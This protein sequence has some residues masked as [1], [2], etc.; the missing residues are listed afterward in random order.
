MQI[1]AAK[2]QTAFRFDKNLLASMKMRAKSLGRSLNSYVSDLII[3][4]LNCNFR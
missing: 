1:V 4:D 2:E 3:Q